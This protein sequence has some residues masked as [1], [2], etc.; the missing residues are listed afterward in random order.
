MWNQYSVVPCLMIKPGDIVYSKYYGTH[1]LIL[2]VDYCNYQWCIYG[3]AALYKVVP[4]RNYSG[5]STQYQAEFSDN[6]S[7]ILDSMPP[8]GNCKNCI[9]YD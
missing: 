7:V 3:N 8:G 5:E 9:Y 6:P 1:L 4:I 2:S